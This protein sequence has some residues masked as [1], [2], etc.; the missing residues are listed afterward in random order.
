[1]SRR[2]FAGAGGGVEVNKEGPDFGGE[3]DGGKEEMNGGEDS[4]GGAVCRVEFG[5]N[6]VGFEDRVVLIQ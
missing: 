3:V 6:V 1:M 2:S 4:S 5:A